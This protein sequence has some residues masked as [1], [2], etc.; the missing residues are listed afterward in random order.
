MTHSLQRWSKASSSWLM[1][2]ISIQ[3]SLD[4]ISL[5]SFTCWTL[6]DLDDPSFPTLMLMGENILMWIVG[7]LLWCKSSLVLPV[8]TWSS[9]TCED[10]SSYF[11]YQYISGL[12]SG[13]LNWKGSFWRT[14]VVLASPEEI[15]KNFM[16]TSFLNPLFDFAAFSYFDVFCF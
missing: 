14:S 12:V 16:F 11:P 13:V 15:F 5:P 3:L 8:T 4:F 6:L 1:V 7:L 10:K 9:P 2:D